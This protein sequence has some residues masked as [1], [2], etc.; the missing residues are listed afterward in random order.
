M[1][2]GMAR[3]R[4]TLL[5]L[6]VLLLGSLVLLFRPI[7]EPVT[8][9]A[10]WSLVEQPPDGARCPAPAMGATRWRIEI[11]G[12]F[13]RLREALHRS[14]GETCRERC[15]GEVLARLDPVWIDEGHF[16]S[17]FSRLDVPV[18]LDRTIGGCADNFRLALDMTVEEGTRGSSEQAQLHTGVLIGGFFR[19]LYDGSA[20]WPRR[21]GG[22]A[23]RRPRSR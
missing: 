22:K 9:V 23:P 8:R 17:G 10:L 2:S 13:P 21:G 19:N 16:F 3:P 18:S 15:V 20:P 5:L 12:D 4:P 6:I 11:G 14:L 7:T 1:L